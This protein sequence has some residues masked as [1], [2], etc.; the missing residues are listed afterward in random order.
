MKIV[1]VIIEEE[2]NF[3]LIGNWT[4]AEGI[5][6]YYDNLTVDVNTIKHYRVAIVVVFFTILNRFSIDFL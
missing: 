1:K 6:A 4:A 3:K 5:Q 2:R